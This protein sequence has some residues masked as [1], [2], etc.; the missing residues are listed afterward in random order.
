MSMTNVRRFLSNEDGSTAIEYALIASGIS[1][2]I[3]GTVTTLGSQVG[4]LFD[5]VAALF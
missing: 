5:K 2:A 1:I 3:V 4:A